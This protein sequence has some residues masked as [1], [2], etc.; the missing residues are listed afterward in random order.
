[1][2]NKVETEVKEPVV[3]RGKKKEIN[4]A[5]FSL[6][7]ADREYQK[8]KA[9]N[10]NKEAMRLIRCR[11]TCNN[12]NKQSYQGEIFCVRNK[13]IPELKKFV[14]FNKVTH[15]PKIIL[16]MLKEKQYQKFKEERLSNG[17]K[18]VKPYLVPEYNI[19]ILSAI[20]PAE[21]EAIKQHQLAEGNTSSK[22]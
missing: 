8:I 9:V 6:A 15:I 21:F 18:V 19:E 4:L 22:E 17:A 7:D 1:M 5:T 13:N 12:T 2:D 10:A 20:T 11:I 3:Q 14:P 16:N